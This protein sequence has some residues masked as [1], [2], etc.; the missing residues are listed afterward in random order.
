MATERKI[1]GFDRRIRLDW[2]DATAD[3]VAQGL[4]VA[5]VR[6]RLERLLD[7]KVAGEGFHSARGKTITVLLH[8]WARLP[9]SLLPLR[10][11]GLALLGERSGR[12]RLPLHWG[13][14]LA[15]YPF[16]RDVARI[17]GRLLSL[18]GAAAHSQIARRMAES[19][20]ERSTSTRAVQRVLRSFVDWGVVAESGERGV[21]S[22]A[23]RITVSAGDRLGLWLTEAGISNGEGRVRPF[24]RV[25]GDSSFF[26]LELKL[27]LREV[28]E[29]P[30]LE[31]YRQ[32]L[33]E[34]LLVLKTTASQR[35]L[36]AS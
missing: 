15:T 9:E 28:A 30:R 3:W 31:V 22:P 24:R 18:Q 12:D 20:G 21:F 17:T 36:P 19:W 34:D 2:L 33:D 23:P 16:V 35:L 8:I 4:A 29:S 26:P 6:A 32:G 7:G 10:D 5:E 25:V 13:M 11:D 27:S 14:C 1:I